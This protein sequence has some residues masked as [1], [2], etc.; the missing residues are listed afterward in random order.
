MPRFFSVLYVFLGFALAPLTEAHGVFET[1][2]K[3]E[4]SPENL[5]VSAVFSLDAARLLLP[6]AERDAF[7][8]ETFADHRAALR[9]AAPAVCTL[10]D[11]AGAALPPERV[12]VTLSHEGEVCFLILHPPAARPARLKTPFL[13]AQAVGAFCVLTDATRPEPLRALLLKD[14]STYAFPSPAPAP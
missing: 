3:I 11:S 7:Q 9:A 13:E 1:S 8:A 6:S 5:E 4:V 10:L 14:K 12:L 2:L